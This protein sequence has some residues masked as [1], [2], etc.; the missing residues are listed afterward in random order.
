[1]RQHAVAQASPPAVEN[2]SAKRRRLFPKRQKPRFARPPGDGRQGCLRYVPAGRCP[3]VRAGL[4]GMGVP[5]MCLE[6]LRRG[7]PSTGGTPVPPDPCFPSFPK[8][9]ILATSP[10]ARAASA[11]RRSLRKQRRLRRGRPPTFRVTAP[12]PAHLPGGAATAIFP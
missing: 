8:K 9:S 12:R 6:I 10:R 3:T 1:M 2:A 4:S 7:A 5:P 11:T